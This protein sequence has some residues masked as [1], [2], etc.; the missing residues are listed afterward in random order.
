MKKRFGFTLV[1][2]LVVI[3]I[4]ALLISIVVPSL[5]AAREVAMRTVCATH[6]RG[7]GQGVIVYAQD[8]SDLVPES[9]YQTGAGGWVSNA[10]L[11]YLLFEIHNNAAAAP[12]QRVSRTYGLGHLFMTDIIENGQLFYCPSA[13]RDVAAAGAGGTVSHH[14][15]FYSRGG[16]DFPWNNDPSGWN[17]NYVRSS[18]NYVPQ[19]SRS[20]QTVSTAGGT[21]DFPVMAKRTSQLFSGHAMSTDL[22]QDLDRLP[23]KKGNFRRAGGVNVLFGDGSVDF[24]N[25]PDAFDSA[26]WPTDRALGS[27]EYLFRTVLMQLQ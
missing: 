3:A 8:N 23:H 6:L 24:R 18:Y 17:T 25:N 12:K 22:L 1:E 5:R 14:Y 27:D 19:A 4:I 2:L 16:T 11:T 7:L 9:Y 20:R 21:G 10:W 13:P 26:L 15:D